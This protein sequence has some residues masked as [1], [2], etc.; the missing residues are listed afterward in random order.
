MCNTFASLRELEKSWEN[1]I[2][3]LTE[4]NDGDLDNQEM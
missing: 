2:K 4:K 1:K 3:K